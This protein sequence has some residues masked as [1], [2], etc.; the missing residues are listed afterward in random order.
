V[1]H[2]KS[3]LRDIEF[4]LFDVLR[5]G[6]LLEAGRFGDLDSQTAR[7]IL[8]E[9]ARLAEGPVAESFA[10][11]DREPVRFD[12]TNHRVEVPDPLRKSILARRE[13][14]WW[15]LGLPEELGGVP[16]PM[17][18]VW[19]V[20]EM[21]CA[22]NPVTQFF[23]LGIQMGE[24]LF[25]VGTPTQRRW[26]GEALE[27]GWA[28]TMVLTEPDAGSDVGAGI[29]KAVPQKDGTWHI[30]G[31]K[32]FISG[33]DVGDV[34]ENVF[35]LVL[36][37]PVGAEPGSKGLSLFFVPK[38]HFNS[39]TMELGDRN[40]VM[41]TGVEHK[42]GIRS[43]PTCEVTFGAHGIPAVGWLVGDVHDGINQMFKAIEGARMMVGTK[44]A[45]TL[46][47]AYLNSLDYATHRVQGSDLAALV[48][49]SA[50][51]VA[52]IRHPEVRRSLLIQKAYAEGL[53][54]LYLF[55]AAHQG[56]VPQLAKLVS[57][58][59]SELSARVNDFLLPIVKGVGSER[60]YDTLKLSLQTLGGSG[61][62]EDYP[63]EQYIRDTMIDTLY[64]GATA[65]Q[66][67]DFFFRKIIRDRSR[68]LDHVLEL[69]DT[70]VD[71]SDHGGALGVERGLL[72]EA[73][74]NVRAMVVTLT[75]YRS[76]ADV[77]P[78]QMYKVG[79]G[80][81]RLLY[82]V[83][84]LL[85]AWRLLERAAVALQAL[86]GDPNKDSFYHGK[87]M[88]A[89][90]FAKSV[91]PELSSAREILSSLSVDVMELDEAAF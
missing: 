38:F 18:L 81:V 36:A 23:E 68:A 51:R 56:D 76:A 91:L 6:D 12:G 8:V 57:G 85:V 65:I 77:E 21:L 22:A 60:A 40:G 37:R 54:S 74:G 69:V 82:S 63:H 86:S 53:R 20:R 35:H 30:E 28:G 62:L 27:R 48:D 75:E 3:N 25:E 16:A 88:V 78:A 11:S 50:P 43:S 9:V 58:A 67:Q 41:V 64:E 33:A 66:A 10:Q 29:T 7:T 79:L 31:V 80:S 70:F 24:V 59:D 2:Y 55:T 13:A 14:G 61:F 34:S 73:L 44:A 90:F 45:G 15:R 5:L 71:A 72:A 89:S 84:D 87:I 83:G 47:T 39:D 19:A 17:P 32:R 46:S 52:I 1:S 4:D 49:K 42:M 26:A